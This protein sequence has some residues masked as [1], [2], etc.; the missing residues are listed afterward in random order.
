[1]EM[2][3]DTIHI[4]AG[5]ALTDE[6]ATAR[7][8]AMPEDYT[9]DATIVDGEEPILEPDFR[10]GS[11]RIIRFLDSGAMGHVYEAEHVHLRK[12]HAIKVIRRKYARMP[13]FV[14]RFRYE[15]R[16]L[17]ALDHPNIVQVTDYG[18]EAG[19]HFFV[20]DFIDGTKVS[21]HTLQDL[22]GPPDNMHAISEDEIRDLFRQICAALAFSHGF[23]DHGIVHRD[24]KPAN[25]LLRDTSD[26]ARRVAV[27]DFGLARMVGENDHLSS[28]VLPEQRRIGH[29]NEA[30]SGTPR[31]MA[32]EQWRVGSKL[33]PAVDIYAV[34]VMLYNALTGDVPWLDS[35][36]LLDLDQ[37]ATLRRPSKA[38]AS[39]YWDP[40]VERCLA[41]EPGDR[42]ASADELARAIA[43]TEKQSGGKAKRTIVATAVG[44]LVAAAVWVG[45]R[46]E[47]SMASHE[48]AETKPEMNAM[49]KPS[50]PPEPPQATPAP[51][52]VVDEEPE[53]QPEPPS[54][55]EARF[56]VDIPVA[57]AQPP[58]FP[59]AGRL[60]VGEQPWEDVSLPHVVPLAPGEKHAI[61][62]SVPGYDVSG[63]DV[64][65]LQEDKPQD[66]RYELKPRPVEVTLTS[67]AKDAAVLLNDRRAGNVNEALRLEPFHRYRLRVSSPTHR[68]RVVELDLTDIARAQPA[69]YVELTPIPAGC[70]IDVTAPHDYKKPRM[71]EI[72]ING[73]S[74]GNKLL[75]FATNQ[76]SEAVWMLG[77]RADGFQAP[78]E[79]AVHLVRNEVQ[80]V[81]FDLAYLE[82]LLRVETTPA[83]A[84]VTMRGENIAN[85]EVSVIPGTVYGVKVDA[86][87]YESVRTNISLQPGES[88]TVQ[89]HLQP[90]TYFEFE[91][92]PPDAT[93]FVGAK[94]LSSKRVRVQPGR[95]YVVAVRA[96]GYKTHSQHYTV[97]RGKTEKLNIRLK[98]KL[99]GF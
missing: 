58:A 49:S 44:A 48:A 95:P 85:Q 27:A 19:F 79:R 35:R 37:P 41:V 64:L 70:T 65:V 6:E 22:L 67:N 69:Y 82:T 4:D 12:R 51:V 66:I 16:V 83:E 52:V 98:R 26:A 25:I 10:L 11:Y 96:K 7:T 76:L 32:P 43:A 55:V 92:D 45:Q 84:S 2:H 93:I 56:L 63:P 74:I 1:M 42:Y 47:P 97:E 20:M 50:E 3:D 28:M 72:L 90:Y 5:P 59:Q 8:V 13:S 68:D 38:G 88:K 81:M 80:D 99:L 17:A 87:G 57:Y 18:H 14:S 23:G 9:L 33:G 31:Y 46:S 24:L 89:V 78:E 62:L 91:T 34:G 71:V 73:K 61:Q 60:K 30:V 15:A 21:P 75:P 94:R 77:L 53:K 86:P 54:A 39:R 29:T 40:I 36:E